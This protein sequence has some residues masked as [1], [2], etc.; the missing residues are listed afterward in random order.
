VAIIGDLLRGKRG[1][2]V[3]PMFMENPSQTKASVQHILDLDPVFLCPG[4]GKPLSPSNI[5]IK[6]RVMKPMEVR[7]K[8][9]NEDIDLEG[10]TKELKEETA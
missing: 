10:L 3:E 9:Q 6:E 5:R 2:L 1:K 7:T 4:H 8:K